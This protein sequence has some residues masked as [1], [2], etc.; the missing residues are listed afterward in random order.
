MTITSILETLLNQYG[1]KAVSIEEVASANTS[2]T[3]TRTFILHVSEEDSRFLIGQYG[4][5]LQ[6]LQHI[7]RILIGKLFPETLGTAFFLD[8]NDYRKKKDQSI[9]D[10]ARSAA[11]EAEKENTTIVL[12]P[13][14]AY[15]R[16][17]VHMELAKETHV[18]TESVGE[19][20]D[21]R[22]HVRSLNT[23]NQAAS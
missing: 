7:S 17:L 12:R 14:S 1:F 5:N 8:V 2:A 16:R 6:A 9:I 13:M 21:R 3:P 10:L 22:I 11:R 19:R 4:N 15:E 18:I 20:G 23:K